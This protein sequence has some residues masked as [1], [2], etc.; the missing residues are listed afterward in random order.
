MLSSVASRL[1]PCTAFRFTRISNHCRVLTHSTGLTPFPTYRKP[2]LLAVV[3]AAGLHTRFRSHT[4][5]R[6]LWEYS[7]RL[8]R[9][10]LWRMHP[11]CTSLLP[12]EVFLSKARV[13]RETISEASS[14]PLHKHLETPFL[15]SSC[16]N[17]IRLI[18][19]GEA[20]Y[21]TCC[22][23]ASLQKQPAPKFS[24]HAIFLHLFQRQPPKCDSFVLH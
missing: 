6:T 7:Q 1:C 2:L 18:H 3:V 17:K 14:L 20:I 23:F 13:V 24:S 4:Y 15:F 5:Y 9:A 22:T 12:P 21:A 10:L 11:R 19:M 16:N 8:D